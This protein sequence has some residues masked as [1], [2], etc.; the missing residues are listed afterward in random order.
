MGIGSHGCG[1]LTPSASRSP[2]D[3]WAAKF[4]GGAC[5]RG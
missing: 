3:R 4:G 5:R 1:D 2:A